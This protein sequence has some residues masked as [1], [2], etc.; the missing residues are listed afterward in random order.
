M[1]LFSLL[2]SHALVQT[3]FHLYP[4]GKGAWEIQFLSSQPSCK[5]VSLDKRGRTV[6]SQQSAHSRMVLSP[7]ILQVIILNGEGKHEAWNFQG[8]CEHSL[9]LYNTCAGRYQEKQSDPKIHKGKAV[10]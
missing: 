9:G 5:E 8:D 6:D 3:N 2:D 1:I 10:I 4:V 7:S